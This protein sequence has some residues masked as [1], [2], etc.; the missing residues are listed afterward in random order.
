MQKTAVSEVVGIFLDEYNGG[1]ADY[2]KAYRIAIRGVKELELDITAIP[3][4]VKLC[5][6]TGCNVYKLPEEFIRE[7]NVGVYT[8]QGDLA[9]LTR[10]RRLLP[11]Q[12]TAYY[13][14]NSYA[15]IVQ[16]DLN[17]DPIPK[18][19]I[20]SYNNIGEY[21]IEGC[22]I[23]FS[24]DIGYSEIILEYL[25][26]TDPEGEYYIDSRLTEALVAYIAYKWH[27][28]KKGASAFDKQYYERQYHKEKDNAKY[29]IKMPTIAD[30]NLSSRKNNFYGLKN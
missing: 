8:T 30:L 4:R 25:A 24:K 12:Y 11:Q 15:P 20:G 13:D 2:A 5:L 23:I 22:N 26:W 6:T 1:E 16:G 27:R 18:D 21:N 29:R 3:K 19:F 17:D 9:C 28:M 7:T 14:S 10:N